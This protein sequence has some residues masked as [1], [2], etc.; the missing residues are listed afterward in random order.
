MVA[1]TVDGDD[2]G[3]CGAWGRWW[4]WRRVGAMATMGGGAGRGAA[5][6]VTPQKRPH[7]HTPP[8]GT[9]P[10]GASGGGAADDPLVGARP[11]GRPPKR[12]RAH[13]SD[14]H[15]PK[16]CLWRG[17][18]GWPARRGAAARTTPPKTTSCPHTTDRYPPKRCLWRGGADGPLVGARP[19]G[20]PPQN[21]LV[22]THSRQVPAQTGRS[23]GWGRSGA[24]NGVVSASASFVSL[25]S[26]LKLRRQSPACTSCVSHEAASDTRQPTRRPRIS[27]THQH[28]TRITRETTIGYWT[29]S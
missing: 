4:W 26:K 11:P 24:R 2:G 18:G 1:V 17:G 19:P 15:P 23:G 10:N 7:G 5:A 6:L 28:D 25:H 8:T 3:D 16:Q 9:R 21:V 14:R 20:R 13:T 22:P 29:D 12:P 27:P